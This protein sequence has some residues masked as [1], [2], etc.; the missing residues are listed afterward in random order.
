MPSRSQYGRLMKESFDQQVGQRPWPSTGARQAAHSR[1][2]ARSS[3]ERRIARVAYAARLRRGAEVTLAKSAVL[4]PIAPPYRPQME[5]SSAERLSGHLRTPA[6][7]RE[8]L[9]L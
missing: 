5:L 3:A 4:S 9:S 6:A 8:T 7:R 2:R 1:G